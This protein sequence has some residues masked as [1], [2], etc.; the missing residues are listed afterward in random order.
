MEIFVDLLSNFLLF[1]F[2]CSIGLVQSMVE[3]MLFYTVITRT[4]LFFLPIFSLSLDRVSLLHPLQRVEI[5]MI[6]AN[7]VQKTSSMSATHPVGIML[8]VGKG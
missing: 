6:K 4:V 8:S 3:M 1:V 7:V 2:V 5:R